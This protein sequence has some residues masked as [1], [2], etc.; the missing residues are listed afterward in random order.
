M[1]RSLDV[2]MR[3]QFFLS[4]PSPIMCPLRNWLTRWCC[5]DWLMWLWLLKAPAQILLLILMFVLRKALRIAQLQLDIWLSVMWQRMEWFGHTIKLA[6][7]FKA[8]LSLFLCRRFDTNT[9][10]WPVVPLAIFFHS[11]NNVAKHPIRNQILI[12]VT[13]IS[14]GGS[15]NKGIKHKH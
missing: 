10:F 7:I 14:K 9:Q 5:W 3:F 2:D 6:W 4:D 1:R 15:R 11:P 13:C 8:V 12:S